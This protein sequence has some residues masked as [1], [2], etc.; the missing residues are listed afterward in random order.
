MVSSNTTSRNQP[1]RLASIRRPL[2][3]Q[4]I[5]ILIVGHGSRRVEANEDVQRA[6]RLIGER[7][8]FTLI[9]AAFLEIEHP[10]VSEGFSRLVAQGARE[11]IVHPYFLS[12]GRHTRG[13]LPREV[14]EIALLHPDVIYRIS[15]PLSDAL[16]RNS[17]Q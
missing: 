10:N 11:I 7:G 12:P 15:E 1:A 16:D 5:G 14:A 8:G 3:N 4:D 17:L 2:S 6:A 9:E 13:D